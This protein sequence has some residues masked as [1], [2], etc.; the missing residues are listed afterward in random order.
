M[1]ARPPADSSPLGQALA[2]GQRLREPAVPQVPGTVPVLTRANR[3]WPAEPDP[4]AARVVAALRREL[5]SGSVRADLQELARYASDAAGLRP[6]APPA[7]VVLPE[8]TAEVQAAMRIASA[9]RVPVVVRGAGS[10][11]SGA[12]IAPP[13]GIVLSTERLTRL[14]EIRPEDELAVVE[15]GV[16]TGDL[17]RAAA[18]HGLRYAPDPASADF[19]TIGGNVA[20]NAGGLR[21]CK[22]GVTRESVLALDVVLADGTLMTVGHRTIKGVTGLDLVGLFVGS[23]GTLG[24]V[25]TVTVRLRPL[26]VATETMVAF[27]DSLGDVGA[28]VQAITR[29]RVQPSAVELLDESS[30]RSIDENRGTDLAARGRAMLLLQTDGHGAT[31]EMDELESVVAAAG[32][33]VQRLVGEEA[34]RMVELRRSGRGSKK[35]TWRIGEDVAVPRSRLV[36]MIAAMEGIGARYGVEVG[37]VAHAG[38]GNLHIGLSAAMRPGEAEPP[39]AV[40]AAADAVVRAALDLGG[41]ITGE[42]GVGALKRPWLE[43]EL[44]TRQLQLQRSVKAAFDPLGILAPDSFLATV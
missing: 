7:A 16:I 35:D 26:P 43:R 5:P 11:L 30:L 27:A 23:E 9:L 1:P 24:V 28:A 18:A 32:V 2:G 38:D 20:M 21:C 25:V 44:G 4:Q 40:H 37:C 17:D 39:A 29:S 34:D 14:I 41:T 19:S 33:S 3:Q 15:A 31:A 36:E 22:Y 12:V 6:G 42:H 13:G 10:G 8:T